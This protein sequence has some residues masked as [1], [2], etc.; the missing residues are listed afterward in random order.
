M[1]TNIK[2]RVLPAKMKNFILLFTICFTFFSKAQVVNKEFTKVLYN[3]TFDNIEKNWENVFNA[4][5]LFIAQNG[6]YELFRKSKKLGYYLMPT[7]GDVFSAFEFESQLSFSDHNNKKQSAGVLLMAQN[8]GTGGL[9]IEINQK[10]EYRI[11]RVYSDKLVP[12]S[13]ST[14]N[15]WV[16]NQYLTKIENNIVIK[17]YDKVFDLYLNGYF[18]VSFT[19]IEM[20][21]GR[22]GIYIGPNSKA[23]FDYLKVKGE[24]SVDLSTITVGNS[25]VEEQAF[26]QIIVKL[27]E[28]INK[29]DKEIDD[30]KT[31]I[32]LIENGTNK[33]SNSSDTALQNN[34]LRYKSKVVV[35]EEENTELQLSVMSLQDR[36][37]KLEEFKAGVQKNQ[38]GDI[39]INL[40]NM[41][42]SQKIKI[43]DLER[44]NKELNSENNGLFVETKDLTKKLDNTS[45]NLTLEQIK[46]RDLKAELDSLK[47]KIISLQDSVTLK[48]K[49]LKEKSES[50]PVEKEISEEE[51]LQ[52][53][54]EKERLER[55][56]RKEEEEQKRKEEEEKNGNG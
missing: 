39:I 26:T 15:G 42:S 5:N 10:K 40:T 33:G 53:M 32:K 13:S 41:V 46:T 43:E 36:V 52:Q 38:D 34:L 19:E 55:I 37:K 2:H 17:T 3:E 48:N 47:K 1:L 8:D 56:K 21:N 31:K 12:I 50:K 18:V 28:Q 6:Y 35:L 27:K 45:T 16:K 20:M 25:K 54:I 24:E 51:L 7:S 49:Q 4:D 44:K 29:K 14:G 30:L 9:L 22:V 23:K 11:V